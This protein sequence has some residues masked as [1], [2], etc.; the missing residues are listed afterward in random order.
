MNQSRLQ[1]KVG[2]FVLIGLVLLAGLLIEFSKGLTLFRSTYDIL[3]R[4]ETAGSLKVR[5]QVLMSGV[6][7]GTVSDIRLAPSGKHVTITLRIFSEYKIYQS[8]RFAIEQSGFLGDEYVAI[9]PT[10]NE[11]EIFKNGDVAHAEPPFN[12]LEVARSATGF[13]KRVDETAQRLNETVIDVR[14]YLLNQETLTN[15][16]VSAANLRVASERAVAMVNNIDELITTNTPAL[17]G[18]VTNLAMFSRELIQF[19]SSLNAL[20]ASN[21]PTF[22]RSLQNVEASTASLKSAM[23]QVQA[24]KG[25]AGA[26]VKDEQI[27]GNLREISRNLSVTTSNLNRLGLWGIL[28]KHREPKQARPAQ[29]PLLSPK[30][31]GE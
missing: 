12:M 23:E 24:G 8:A 29:E 31:A 14:R 4:S 30:N 15:L 3:L 11:G 16:A 25:L 20:L 6:Q 13:V 7:V 1:W 9:I 2:L 5:A 18:T 19:S 21:T 28:W 10:N 22:N 26:L 27:A 17:A